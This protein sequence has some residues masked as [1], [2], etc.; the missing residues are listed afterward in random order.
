MIAKH[1]LQF[2]SKKH[3]N[4]IKG[5]KINKHSKQDMNIVKCFEC[6]K[7]GYYRHH[8]PLIKEKEKPC[9]SNKGKKTMIA[10]GQHSRFL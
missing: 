4:K 7:K 8:W 9:N 3:L 1:L 2:A 5:E 6:N 10:P